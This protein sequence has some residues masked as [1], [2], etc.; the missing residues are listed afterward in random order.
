MINQ[1]LLL[2]IKVTEELATGNVIPTLPSIV[3]DDVVEIVTVFTP[4]FLIV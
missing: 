4:L 1:L 2:L 3:C